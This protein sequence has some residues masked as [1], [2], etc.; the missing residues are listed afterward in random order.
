MSRALRVLTWSLA[1]AA[2]WQTVNAADSWVADYPRVAGQAQRDCAGPQAHKCRDGLVRL[3]ALLDGRLDIIYRLARVEARLGHADASLRYLDLYVRSRLNLGDPALEAD[4]HGLRADA[5][6]KQLATSFRAGLAPQGQHTVLATLPEPD[7]VA[8]DLGLDT[9]DGTRYFSS[10]H[11]GTVLSLDARGQ[12]R[13]LVGHTGL[14]AWGIYAVVVDPMRERLWLSTVAGPVSPPYRIADQGRSAVLRLALKNHSVEHRYELA[15]GRAHAFGDMA[16]GAQGELYVAD[17]LDGGVYRIDTAADA[18]LT[19][20]VRHGL[21]RSPQT[22]V[23]LADGERLLV[24]DYSRGIAVIDLR[25]RDRVTWLA[26]PPEL[27][28]YGIDGLYLRGQ[29]LIAVQN[30]TLPERLLLLHLDSTLSRI[31]RWEVALAG[32]PGLG[33]PTHGLL[34][35]KQFQ[36]IANSGW[37]RVDDQGHVRADPA[38]GS[39]ALWSIELPEQDP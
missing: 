31:V 24:P 34:A 22:P 27:A 5:R 19:H 9:R 38:A 7:V 36:F 25:Q 15:D 30:G 8:E 2:G 17:G 3:A 6:F 4:F 16:L 14:A 18:R 1:T 13:E 26:H 33:D 35:G 21:L 32:A 37:D 28:L 29:M 23:P 20:L 11:K 39:P 10:V 12:W